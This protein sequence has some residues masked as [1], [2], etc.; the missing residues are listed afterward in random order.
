MASMPA[1]R[2]T[3]TSFASGMA[4]YATFLPFACDFVVYLFGNSILRRP[5][6]R[7]ISSSAR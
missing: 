5:R 6:A 4:S 2:Y 1:E 3:S 7:E